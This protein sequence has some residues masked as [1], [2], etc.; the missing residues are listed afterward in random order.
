MTNSKANNLVS[1]YL[2]DLEEYLDDGDS[3]EAR[4]L[5]IGK[6]KAE[7]ELFKASEHKSVM[8]K[9]GKHKVVV[10]TK[11]PPRVYSKPFMRF[12]LPCDVYGKGVWDTK[13]DMVD[14]FNYMT[15]ERFDKLGFVR[16]DYGKYGR[17]TVKEVRVGIH[18]FTFLV[19]FVVTVYENNEGEPS[20]IF[21]RDFLVTSKS[22]V[23]F[24]IGEMCI[25]LTM[26]AEENEFNAILEG[27]VEKVE[28]V[29]SFNGE[30]VN[31]GKASRNKSH[32]E[33]VK[34]AL[35]QKYK[36]LKQSKPILEVLENNM[37]YRKKLDEVMMGRARVNSMI[38]M[39]ALAD[40][41]ASVS[42]LPYSLFKNL[43]LSDPKPYNSNL[44]MV[45]NTQAKAMGEVRNTYLDNFELD[46]EDD[47]LSCL[48]VGRDEDGNPKYGPV[49]PSFL[50]I[51]YDME[52]SLAM[53]AYFNLF[54]N[55]IVFKKLIDFLVSLPAQL[56]N[57]DWGNKGHGVNKKIEGDGSW[58][59]KF[60]VIT[61]SG[62]KFT[63]GFKTK[64]TKRKLSG[65]FT[66]KDILKFD[67]FL[68]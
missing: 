5:T 18:G 58:H 15:E 25:D 44:T 41:G 63:R 29:G 17:K 8:I 3:L 42:V 31:M 57:I 45:D 2:N 30:L 19:D 4:K 49:A 22:K 48:E 32:N 23:D 43:R 6:S 68:D 56:K 12:S 40:T 21:G 24:G 1:K 36:E 9:E 66:S 55:I 34:E 33:K 52:R 38:E 59:A 27:L 13:L 28:E 50:D 60:K 14:S 26:L 54:K 35:D 64:E 11:A 46:E 53:E 39:S 20:V 62:R 51:E 67:H 10:F 7:L 47:W 37:T 65:K 61:P 16:V